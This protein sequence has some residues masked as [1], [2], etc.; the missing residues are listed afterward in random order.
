V[1]ARKARAKF[2]KE[3]PPGIFR[4]PLNQPFAVPDDFGE[5]IR[6]LR[7]TGKRVH[8]EVAGGFG[9]FR[10]GKGLEGAS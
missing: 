6:F 10:P 8:Q 2:D 5:D 9:S 4:K 1:Q 7:S 3:L